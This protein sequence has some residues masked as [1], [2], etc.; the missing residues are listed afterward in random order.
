M[1]NKKAVSHFKETAFSIL[2]FYYK[3]SPLI[4]KAI[5]PSG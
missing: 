5:R 4:F 1:T 2:V 3:T